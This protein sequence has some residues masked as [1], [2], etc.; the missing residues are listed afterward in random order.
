L[1][2]PPSPLFLCEM[3]LKLYLGFSFMIFSAISLESSGDSSSTN[4]ISKDDG[5]RF[6]AK[7]E[8]TQLLRYFE[9]L[10]IG[11][12]NESSIIINTI[13]LTITKNIIFVPLKL[14][15]FG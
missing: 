8:A 2:A 9:T 7:I 4:R 3:S 6:V 5:I 13:H 15:F 12:I 1:R 11:R 14:N 10:Y